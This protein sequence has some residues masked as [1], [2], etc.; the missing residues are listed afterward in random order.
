M[1]RSNSFAA[2]LLGVLVGCAAGR[3][4]TVPPAHAEGGRR[5]EYVCKDASGE[6]DATKMAN[7]FGQ[8]GWELATAGTRNS[9]FNED[10]TWCF[11]R[12]L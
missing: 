10:V 11:K 12:P 5:W 6:K 9:H 2:L 4:L 1:S 7:E 8:Q 3:A